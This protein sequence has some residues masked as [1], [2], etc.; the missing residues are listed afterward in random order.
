MKNIQENCSLDLPK[1][2]QQVT[3]SLIKVSDIFCFYSVVRAL[4]SCRWHL[5][6]FQ[7]LIARIRRHGVTNAMRRQRQRQKWQVALVKLDPWCELI[8]R[9]VEKRSVSWYSFKYRLVFGGTGSVEGTTWRNWVSIRWYWLVL[10]CTWSL[11][12]GTGC[13]LVVVGQYRVVLV[14]TWW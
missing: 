6:P 10:D 12:G 11:E 2:A 5:R 8:C 13:Y 9:Q 14:G 3:V 1:T 4:Q 7:Q